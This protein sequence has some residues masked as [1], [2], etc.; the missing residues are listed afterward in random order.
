MRWD[1]ILFFASIVMIYFGD[2]ALY[3]GVGGLVVSVLHGTLRS[4]TTKR[5]RRMILTIGLVGTGIAFISLGA[6]ALKPGWFGIA[7]ITA[8]NGSDEKSIAR[9]AELGWTIKSGATE[10]EF[11]ASSGPLP[12]MEQSAVYFRQLTKLITL[13][14]G[15]VTGLGGLHY[16]ADIAECTKI[17]ISAGEFSDI[18][19][20]QGFAHLTSLGIS[21]LP[22]T[23]HDTVDPSPLASLTNLERLNLNMT[24][25]RTT[26]FLSKLNHIKTLG[27]GQTLITDIA[28]IS[29]LPLLETLDIRGTRVTDLRP[30]ESSQN[31]REITIGGEQIPGLPALASLKNLK[32]ITLIEQQSFDLSPV[33]ALANLQSIFIWGPFAGSLDVS[34]LQKLTKLRDLTITAGGFNNL[35]N[36]THLDSISAMTELRTLTLGQIIVTDLNFLSELKKL[37]QINLNQIP[38]TS[39]EPLRGLKAL[40]K[41]S[42]NSLAVTDI[43][44]LLD[45]PALTDVTIGRTPARSDVIEELRRRGVNVTTY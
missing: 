19:E 20:L 31:L 40:R 34:P 25:I 33:A 5:A 1:F 11:Q 30:L 2:W 39:I 45:L 9:L 17:E 18:S 28:A 32:K 14:L 29:N 15:Q 44:P 16:L 42:L 38:I 22:L 43:S 13:Q 35:T 12:P 6:F 3:F 4:I 36:V 37:T 41:L 8:N 26:D 21:Q 23:K 7:P 10:I 27:L 24:K